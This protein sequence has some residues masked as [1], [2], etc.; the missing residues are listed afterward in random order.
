VPNVAA[1]KQQEATDVPAKP[2]PNKQFLTSTQLRIRYGG[3]SGMWLV[4]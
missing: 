3:R 4:A 1:S 2:N